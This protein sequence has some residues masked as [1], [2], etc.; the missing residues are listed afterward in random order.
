MVFCS[1]SDSYPL[2][3]FPDFTENFLQPENLEGNTVQVLKNKQ[4]VFK[5]LKSSVDFETILFL[6][7]LFMIIACVD[8]VGII[9]DIGNFFLGIGNKNVFLL[10]TLIVFGSVLISAFID[11]I[12]YVATMLPVIAGLGLTGNLQTLLCFGLLCGATLGGNITPVGASANVVA[13][14]MLGKEGYKVKSSDFFKIGI[15]FTMVAVLG[16][17]LLLWLV[18]GI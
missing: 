7:S 6:I 4:N 5:T 11:N 8:A 1:L 13:I 17:Y 14:G 3:L 9:D 12:P 16:G 18:W 15:P 2:V 10:Y